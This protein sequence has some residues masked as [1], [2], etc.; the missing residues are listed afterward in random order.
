MI[1]VVD[2]VMGTGLAGDMD[3]EFGTDCDL[4]R[5][6]DGLGVVDEEF[7]VACW[8]KKAQNAERSAEAGSRGD[9]SEGEEGD[10]SEREKRRGLPS[11]RER[12]PTSAGLGVGEL[13]ARLG[14]GWIVGRIG[15][16]V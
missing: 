16:G 9:D 3:V 10:E 13:R 4:V 14:V 2:G 6:G 15:A 12:L 11:L 5:R 8:S 7:G 1:I